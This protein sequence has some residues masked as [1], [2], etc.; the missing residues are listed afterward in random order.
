MGRS[1]DLLRELQLVQSIVERKT[2]MPILSNVLF[3]AKGKY[4]TT[5]ATDLEVGVTSNVSASVLRPGRVT[6]HARGFYDVVRELPEEMVHVN[7]KENHWVEV[8]CGRSEFKIA[9]LPPHEFP[10]LPLN[11]EG[12]ACSFL[13]SDMA[14]MIEK[15]AFAMSTDETRYNLNGVLL[16]TIEASKETRLRMVAT[17]GH[18]LSINERKTDGKW[19]LPKGV[20]V[21]RKG[22]AEIKKLV[23]AGDGTFTFRAD[24]KHITAERDRASL[25]VRLI[26]GQF[27]PYGQ[28]IPKQ[29][30]R[31]V[32]LERASLAQALKRVSAVTSERSR[33]VKFSI[34][35]KNL[36]ITASTP[37][38][39]EAREQLAVSYKG[40]PFEI[41]FNARYFLE[42]LAH[43]ED[44]QAVLQLG[45]DTAPCLVQSETDRGFQH[46]IMPMRL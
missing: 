38:V 5:T 29:S 17:D 10:Q 21:P 24:G 26:D 12:P 42:A 37:D 46:I 43:L 32:S 19:K 45:D 36:E 35:P 9:G 13:C 28:V 18:R 1:Q 8:R 22:I 39:G 3:E 20:I 25:V 27:P 16:E 14:A 33:G 6:V 30:K 11:I 15:T 41:G 23:E 31:I 4:L 44:E 34:S 7:V 40:D 2:T